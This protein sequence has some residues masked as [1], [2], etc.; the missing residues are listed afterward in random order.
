MDYITFNGDTYPAFQAE[1]FSSRFIFPFAQ[2]YCEGIGYDIGCSKD[3][4]A[5]PGAIPIDIKFNDEWDAF[6]LPDRS[7]DF[8]FSSHC[9]EHIS[10]WV[11]ALQYWTSKLKVDGRMFLYLPHYDQQYWRP[12]N[13]RKHL[14]VFT[15]EI[16][17]DILTDFGY[18]N[19]ESTGRDLN[20]SFAVTGVKKRP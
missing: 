19:L 6:Y 11:R 17:T 9:L 1:G 13:N 5:L 7:V 14:H 10:D 16:I 3:E 4:W 15:P 8:I 2:E 20:H 12:W 18:S